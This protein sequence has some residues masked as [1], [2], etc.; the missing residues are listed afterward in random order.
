MRK[1]AD[2]QYSLL[3]KGFSVTALSFIAEWHLRSQSWWNLASSRI[4]K[5]KISATCQWC[6]DCLRCI[7][8]HFVKV[9]SLLLSLKESVSKV[10]LHKIHLWK[11]QIPKDLQVCFIAQ[12]PFAKFC[13][14]IVNKC[15]QNLCWKQNLFILWK[16]REFGIIQ[17]VSW[18][19][20]KTYLN[21][22][23]LSMATLSCVCSE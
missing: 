20:G 10:R 12:Y 23:I 1:H 13:S 2:I 7:Q 4:Q 15:S 21:S 14:G 9:L 19:N 17:C 11:E 22:F 5:K 18:L 16:C 8:K 6:E 3:N